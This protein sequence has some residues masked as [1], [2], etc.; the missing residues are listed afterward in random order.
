VRA[1]ARLCLAFTA[2]L[3]LANCASSEAIQSTRNAPAG[4]AAAPEASRGK[5]SASDLACLAE[6]IYFEAR[7]TGATGETAVAHVVVNRAESAKFPGSICGVVGDGCQFSY[8]CDGQP[9]AL[10][11]AGARARAFRVAQSV[12]EGAPDFTKGA[13]FFHSARA[14]PGWF[15]SRPRVGTFG[16]NV[17]YR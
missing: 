12:L 1:L 15:K 9:D 8:R 5:A 14:A 13:L 2:V 17:F 11:D 16:G 7:G 6:A 10:A 3:T 4:V